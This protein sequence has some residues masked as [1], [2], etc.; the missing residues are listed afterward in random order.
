MRRS[1]LPV[2]LA[3]ALAAGCTGRTGTDNRTGGGSKQN[4]IGSL[5]SG[6]FAAGDRVPAPT[7]R[8][9]TLEDT[10]LDLADL[11]GK[12]V[13]VNFWAQWCAPC[14]A[15]ARNL[16]SVYVQTKDLGVEFIGINI[17]DDRTAAKAFQRSKKVLY[18]S[19]FD[20]PGSLLLKFR[21]QA[22]QQPPTTLILDRQGRVA[23]R[24]I[25]GVTENQLLIP[26][27]VLAKERA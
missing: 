24:F 11:R 18:P 3:V 15:E 9:R 1:L 2:L 10:E 14:R 7:L 5:E 13:V 22:P 20:Q 19:L 27:Q 17:K 12:V 26:V 6:V 4:S 25:G 23:A 16:N 8:G 21:G